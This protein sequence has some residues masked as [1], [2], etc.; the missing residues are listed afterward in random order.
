VQDTFVRHKMSSESN[1][2]GNGGNV[3]ETSAEHRRTTPQERSTSPSL[4]THAET[5]EERTISVR[6]V[7]GGLLIGAMIC[8]ANLYFLLQA[9]LNNSMPLPSALLGYMVFQPISK[10]LHTPY[11][12]MENVLVMTIAASMGAMPVTAGLDGII[13][14]LEY[15][16]TPRDN[17]P[18]NF[19]L[20][21]LILWS[22][23]V[24]LFGI[25]FAAPLRYFFILRDPLRFPTGT[26]MAMVIGL[27]HK[28]PDITER[29]SRDQSQEKNI[30]DI[31]FREQLSGV[32]EQRE[33]PSGDDQLVQV[34]NESHNFIG[35]GR[36][37]EASLTHRVK[38]MLSFGFSGLSVNHKSNLPHTNSIND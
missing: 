20:W 16:I 37:S 15:L 10:Y 22:S 23:G 9:G 2:N 35:E 29:I 11:S 1:F 17:G 3:D 27:L 30:Y 25:V 33:L 6:A 19:S 4:R 8:F 24:C 36:G 26:A 31:K 5:I 14:A 32:E 13:P 21:D 18:M 38:L 34:D 12:P 28:R 7:I